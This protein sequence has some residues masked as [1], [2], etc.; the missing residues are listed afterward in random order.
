MWGHPHTA[1]LPLL[2]SPLHIITAFSRQQ[3]GP[4][5]SETKSAGHAYQLC[6]PSIGRTDRTEEIRIKG[7]LSELP[8]SVGRSNL[9]DIKKKQ[10]SKTP[11]RRQRQTARP[12]GLVDRGKPL[13]SRVAAASDPA[14]TPAAQL[15]AVCRCSRNLQSPPG[16][17][18]AQTHCAFLHSIGHTQQGQANSPHQSFRTQHTRGGK[19]HALQ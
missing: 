3:N 2:R 5:A 4:T 13:L 17:Y 16:L 8:S 14:S 9:S 7:G 1:L 11:A 15:S 19:T 10:S 6:Q 18:T 12:R